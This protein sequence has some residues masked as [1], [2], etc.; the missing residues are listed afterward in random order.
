MATDPTYRR[1]NDLT[2]QLEQR[3]WWS[4]GRH[5]TAGFLLA[6]G[7]MNAGRKHAV[8]DPPDGRH[9]VGIKPLASP[10]RSHDYRR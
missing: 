3:Q 5:L 7:L 9:A 4:T 6:V 1:L 10:C 8:S 2:A